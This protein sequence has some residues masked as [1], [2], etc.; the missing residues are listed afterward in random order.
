MTTN[1][2]KKST[3][4]VFNECH[5]CFNDF[6]A[7]F[8]FCIFI[9]TYLLS[10]ETPKSILI[11][12]STR[13]WWHKI[14]LYWTIDICDKNRYHLINYMMMKKEELILYPIKQPQKNATKPISTELFKEPSG[15]LFLN[16]TFTVTV[17]PAI[18]YLFLAI[19]AYW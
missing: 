11:Q 15:H 5:I 17:V 1:I 12:K 9:K 10:F 13:T 16:I 4:S 6:F 18:L 8:M 2:P 3:L 14:H 19:F 7:V